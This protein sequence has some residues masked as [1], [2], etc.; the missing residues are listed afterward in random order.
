MV[1]AIP[2][3]QQIVLESLVEDG[4]LAHFRLPNLSVPANVVPSRNGLESQFIGGNSYD[5]PVLL[6]QI[7]NDVVG[8]SADYGS[9]D[10]PAS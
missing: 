5:R 2:H 6:V 8:P 9:S 10:T 7:K 4:F 3:S 1:F